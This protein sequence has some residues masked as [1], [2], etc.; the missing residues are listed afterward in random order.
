MPAAVHPRDAE[1]RQREP[2]G[3][4]ER[5]QHEQR[6]DGQEVV[7]GDRVVVPGQPQVLLN[8]LPPLR[9]G[10]DDVAD[11]PG[12][13][14]EDRPGRFVRV[15][16]ILRAAEQPEGEQRDDGRRHEDQRQDGQFTHGS[17]PEEEFTTEAPRT[18]RNTEK[19]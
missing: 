15:R 9:R 2:D 3:Q 19:N 5:E 17:S 13:R 1:G 7:Q 18:Q 12:E 6:P 14:A 4:A 11:E 16:V 10:R 8:L